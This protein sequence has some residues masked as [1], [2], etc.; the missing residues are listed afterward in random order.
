MR[1]AIRSI[2]LLSALCAAASLHAQIDTV[3]PV[4]TGSRVRVRFDEN[5]VARTV[6]GNVLRWEP[7]TVTLGHAGGSEWRIPTRDVRTVDVSRGKGVVASHILIGAGAGLVAGT[8]VGGII[9]A[10]SCNDC[11]LQGLQAVGGM[12]VGAVVGG[13]GGAVV[14]MA[15][16]GERWR[17]VPIQKPTVSIVPGRQRL[18]VVYSVRF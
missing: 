4:P 7:D 8:L 5:H 16:P 17:Q 6:I 1:R 11:F 13:A 3:P 9:G 15:I 2:L 14:G 18:T 12:M 10:N